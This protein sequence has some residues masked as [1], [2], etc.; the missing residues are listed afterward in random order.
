MSR[1]KTVKNAFA[2]LCRGGAAALVT[3]LL[4][5]FLTRILPIEAYNTWL[6]I[7]QLGTYV[8]L[9]D[10]GI[11]TAVGRYVAYCNELGDKRKRDSI[12]SNAIGILTFVGSLALIGV[13]MA[14]WQLPHLFPSMPVALQQDA[15]LA[16]LAVGSSLAIALPFN[17]FGA[18]FIGLQRYD[19]PAWI[20][21][22]SRILGGFFV[23]LIA[24]TSHSIAM[25]GLAMG[26][27]N[28]L[29][30][31]WQYLAYRR[32]AGDIQ[33]SVKQLSKST[34]IEITN[35]CAGLLVWTV[36]MLLVSGLDTA[37]IGYFDYR[38]VVYYS[39]AASLTMFVTGLQSSVFAT[40]LPNAAEINARGDRVGLGKLLV[41]STRYATVMLVFTSLPLLLGGKLLLTIWVGESYANN[42]VIMLHLLIIAGFIRQLG[43]PYATIV[44][45][46]GEQ[47]LIMLSPLVEGVVNL[48]TSILLISKIGVIGVAI[49]T[50]IGGFVSVLFH[51]FYNLPRTK[52]IILPNAYPL[53]LAVGKP[54]MAMLPT[55]ILYTLT[56]N[57]NQ[58]PTNIFSWWLIVAK[59]AMA[60]FSTA[61]ITYCYV[62]TGEERSQFVS[63]IKNRLSRNIP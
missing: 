33:I 52:C 9:L 11:Q 27:A 34:A 29:T 3:L 62:V 43:A 1:L 7:L 45:A 15:K 4:P 28:L 61:A 5:P 14:T 24:H 18:V 59:M 47:K 58:F 12:V 44:M 39:L 31:V 57:S 36:G 22:I 53:I 20:I 6:L 13:A 60:M 2:N 16:L 10:F 30:G 50:I 40:I 54:L 17:V 21:G 63:F 56:P 35:Y 55:I 26:A 51:L 48:A 41:A 19:V 38:S 8:S 32:L 49:G 42:T 37:I 23:I 25:M 46:S